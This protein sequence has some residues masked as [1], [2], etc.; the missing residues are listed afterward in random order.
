MPDSPL[1]VGCAAALITPFLPGGALDEAA[2]Q[3]LILRQ[4]DAHADA[5]VLLGTTGEPSTLDMEERERIIR[6]GI[7]AANGRIPVI[8]GTG[9]NDTKKSI[10][11]AMQAKALGADAQLTVT[12][13]YNKAS[14][15]GLIRHFSAIMDCCDLPMIV[16]NVPSRTG[17]NMQ[18]EAI[19]E[20]AVH[21]Q[22]IGV[23]EA[24]GIPSSTAEII[25]LTHG[26]LPVYCGNDDLIVP[27]MAIGAAG[28][29]SVAANAVPMKVRAITTAC[30]YGR[31]SDASAM[32]QAL[33]PLVRLLSAQVNPIPIKAAISMMGLIHD[34]LRLPLT[35]LEE[36]YRTQLI[37]TLT[38]CNLLQR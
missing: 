22:L 1:F 13:Y 12:P 20:L 34:E 16:Y 38:Q 31:F 18:P 10:A 37:H 28:A 29:I 33:A 19:A 35:P 5:L 15:S 32:Q 24:S 2:L 26:S 36:P 30:L 7:E 8:I 6:I 23:K 21:P 3:K 25:E 17:V 14:R 4:I 9:S 11:Y 27:L